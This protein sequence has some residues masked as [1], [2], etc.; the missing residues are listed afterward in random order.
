MSNLYRTRLWQYAEQ[1]MLPTIYYDKLYRKEYLPTRVRYNQALFFAGFLGMAWFF[2]GDKTGSGMFVQSS[3][4][5]DLGSRRYYTTG[6]AFVN[7][8]AMMLN[9]SAASSHAS[10]QDYVL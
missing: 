10:K 2:M 7:P 5:S 9:R 1:N 6:R 4:K 8:V 3:D